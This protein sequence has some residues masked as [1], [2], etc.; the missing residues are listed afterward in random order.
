MLRIAANYS[1]H[2]AVFCVVADLHDIPTVDE[3]Y[4]LETEIPQLLLMVIRLNAHET[5]M[6]GPRLVPKPT[7]EPSFEPAC[8]TVLNWGSSIFDSASL[9]V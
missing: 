2:V 1:S 9:R 7:N 5:Y 3:L 4:H 6:L 8:Q